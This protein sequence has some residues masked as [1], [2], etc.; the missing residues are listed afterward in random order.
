MIDNETKNHVKAAV[1]RERNAAIENHG[2]F[3]SA[4][5][6]W[7]VLLEEVEEV[8]TA[9]ADFKE[10]AQKKMVDLWDNV[11]TDFNGDTAEM[12]HDLRNTALELI[13][14]CVQVAAVCNKWAIYEGEKG[15]AVYVESEN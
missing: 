15:A 5:E 10:D 2:H 9:F 6:G 4:H 13:Y 1:S 8:A 11:R 14:E 3:H 12:L 7:A